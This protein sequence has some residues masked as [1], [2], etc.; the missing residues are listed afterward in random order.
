MSN[1]SLENAATSFKES[2]FFVARL[3]PAQ[4]GALGIVS[5]YGARACPTLK[6]YFHAFRC[7]SIESLGVGRIAVGQWNHEVLTGRKGGS[8][9]GGGWRSDSGKSGMCCLGS[10]RNSK[11]GNPFSWWQSRC[12]V[13]FREL[14]VSRC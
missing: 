3:T 13:F 11:L 8:L 10:N 1:R 9:I 2:Q 4:P 14:C 7:T 12:S 6:A 5:I